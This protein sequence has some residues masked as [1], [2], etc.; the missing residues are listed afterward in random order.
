MG[1]LNLRQRIAQTLLRV[2]VWLQV[3][4][5]SREQTFDI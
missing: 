3:I 5:I 4:V 1:S 2:L